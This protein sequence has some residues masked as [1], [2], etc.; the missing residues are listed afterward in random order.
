M[1][2]T[3]VCAGHGCES[4]SAPAAPSQGHVLL[5]RFLY[6]TA[7]KPVSSLGKSV[8]KCLRFAFYLIHSAC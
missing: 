3:Y 7:G 6:E 1:C 5:K 2:V 8:T 4:L